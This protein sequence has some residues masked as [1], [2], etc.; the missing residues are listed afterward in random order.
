MKRGPHTG[1]LVWGEVLHSWACQ[2]IHNPR[3]AGA[4]FFGWT[5][6]RTGPEG[7]KRVTRQPR[8]QWIL[9]PGIHRAISPGMRTKTISADSRRMRRRAGQIADARE[10]LAELLTGPRRRRMFSH[11]HT[12]DA[13]PRVGQNHQDQ[14][15]TPRRRRRH[16]EI[17]GHDLSEVVHQERAP[18]L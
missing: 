11:R 2:L 7:Q 6:T 1:E 8:D 13:T 9:R 4:F 15:E 3:Y 14:L 5:R 12:N 16:E 10:C 18:R 17:R